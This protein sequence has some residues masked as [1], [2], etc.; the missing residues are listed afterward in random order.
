MTI[1]K[2]NPIIS[3]H[4]S[5]IWNGYHKINELSESE[6][7]RKFFYAEDFAVLY[8][9]MIGLVVPQYT[10]MHNTAL[11]LLQFHFEQTINSS[12]EDM[13]GSI[14]DI[15]CGTGDQTIALMDTFPGMSVVGVDL[16]QSILNIF[17]NKIK[18]RNDI[19]PRIQM[20]CGNIFGD[21]CTAPK[22]LEKISPN[23]ENRRYRAAISGL[24]LHH[25]TAEEKRK[26]Y[27]RVFEALE[28]DGVFINADLF[29]YQSVEFTEWN[30]ENHIKRFQKIFANHNP[31]INSAM[32]KEICAELSI[33][34]TDHYRR[35]N[36]LFPTGHEEDL[37]SKQHGHATEIELLR[38]A[39]FKQITVPYRYWLTGIT[40]AKK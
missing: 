8:D 31:G 1:T 7:N 13:E 18:A 37:L 32:T 23:A 36:L 11:E 26:T 20:V 14:L 10:L 21:A 34:W 30:R 38:E 29:G 33:Y 28:P 12:I 4:E 17:A 6:R 35:D 2:R 5:D 3:I 40:V 24:T 16:C 27:R 39:G 9:Q 19:L 15:G 25:L 22:L